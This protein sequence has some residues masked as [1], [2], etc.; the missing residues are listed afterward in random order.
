[1]PSAGSSMVTD[2]LSLGAM[3]LAVAALILAVFAYDGESRFVHVLVLCFAI[4]AV[5]WSLSIV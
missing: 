5:F 2:L 3:V 1:M 4:V